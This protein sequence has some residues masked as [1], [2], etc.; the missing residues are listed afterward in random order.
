M[1]R[2][3]TKE[4]IKSSS[5]ESSQSKYRQ[6]ITKLDTDSIMELPKSWSGTKGK[7][8]IRHKAIED[9][10]DILAYDNDILSKRPESGKDDTKRWM[11]SFLS[12]IEASSDAIMKSEAKTIHCLHVPLANPFVGL[13]CIRILTL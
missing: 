7:C 10:R 1:E 13:Y 12:H 9:N 6:K 2:N 5:N 4:A 8:L 3:F 11:Q